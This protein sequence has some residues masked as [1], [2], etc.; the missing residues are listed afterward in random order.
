MTHYL[1]EGIILETASCKREW[2]LRH[3]GCKREWY[4]RRSFC[5]RE[6]VCVWCTRCKREWYVCRAGNKVDV[7][8]AI[9]I[10][11]IWEHDKD[12]KRI[13]ISIPSFVAWI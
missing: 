2:Y 11:V 7:S 1:Q 4:L 3:T 9:T 13:T 10:D 5:K 12:I 8:T 6:G